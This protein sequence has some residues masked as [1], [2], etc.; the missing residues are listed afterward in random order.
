MTRWYLS[1]A[2]SAHV[3]ASRVVIQGQPSQFRDL[4]ARDLVTAAPHTRLVMDGTCVGTHTHTHTSCCVELSLSVVCQV[5]NNKLDIAAVH[6]LKTEQ[7]DNAA[8]ILMRD[9]V[10]D[11]GD[12]SR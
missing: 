9:A 2:D 6:A 10:A 5:E 7:F 1:Q 12:A 4:V 11:S 3:Y 8:T